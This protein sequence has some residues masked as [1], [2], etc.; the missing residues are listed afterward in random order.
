[1]KIKTLALGLGLVGLGSSAYATP[2][3]VGSNL[4]PNNN[5]TL[6]FMDT[7]TKEQTPGA[8]R[9]NIAAFELKA[10]Y[11]V[12]DRL[13]IN[14]NLPFY[15]ANAKAAGT[16]RSSLGNF[17]L[18]GIWADR[19][20]SPADDL[21]WGYAVSLD[22]YLPTSRKDEAGVVAVA[23]PTTEL[24]RFTPKATTGHLQAGLWIGNEMFTVKG[25][26]GYAYSNVSGATDKARSTFTMQTAASWRALPNLAVNAEYNAIIL[27][28]KFA[29]AGKKFRHA[30]TPSISGNIDQILLAGFVTLPLDSTT[31]DRQSVAF[32]AN[33]GYL[34]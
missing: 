26:A 4:D 13:A 34:F 11:F 20:S 30:M 21:S 31:R 19:L 10:D 29:G 15:M 32:G 17:S 12:I 24:Y 23:N 1:M 2:Y 22:A 16:S 28:S 25:N 14:M 33:V 6:G 7:P 9:G 5:I 8:G 18:G 3:Y 27:D